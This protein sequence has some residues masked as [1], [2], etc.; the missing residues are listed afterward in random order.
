MKLTTLISGLIF[1]FLSVACSDGSNP[2][3][4]SNASDSSSLRDQVSTGNTLPSGTLTNTRGVFGA[5][6]IA[7][8][9]KTLTAEILPAR[10]AKAIGNIFD[11]D[12]SQFLEVSPCANCVEVAS[13]FFD[14]Y[15]NHNENEASVQQSGETTRS[16]RIRCPRDFHNAIDC[17]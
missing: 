17:D 7:V 15:D 3:A 6:Q 14:G 16:A 11:A 12:L 10:N 1:I 9:S 4:P 2:A 5:W 13:V 8:D